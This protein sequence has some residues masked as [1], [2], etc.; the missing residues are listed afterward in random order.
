MARVISE[1]TTVPREIPPP[2]PAFSL[3]GG[4]SPFLLVPMLLPPMVALIAPVNVLDSMWWAKRITEWIQSLAPF[5]DM[6]AHANSTVYP[7]V[8]LLVHSLT[9]VVIPFTGVVW[10]ILSLI[11]Y[12][13]NLARRRAIGRMPVRQHLL[14][15]LIGPPLFLGAIYVSV[16]LPGD[17]SFA[18]GFT[19]HNR[20]G[21]AI[22]TLMGTYGTAMM[23]GAQ[24]VN[25]RLFIDTYLK[26]GD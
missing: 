10:I 23:L 25:I 17:P 21:F 26:S 7:Q 6:T 16:A 11:S 8:A 5:I 13:K 3:L 9:I 2:I 15:L 24:V 4:L 1:D 14:I 20:S 12:P 19:T 18:L 22:L